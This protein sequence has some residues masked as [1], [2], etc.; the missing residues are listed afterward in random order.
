MEKM[1]NFMV[2]KELIDKCSI[3][4][5]TKVIAKLA[6]V[7]EKDFPDLLERCTNLIQEIRDI[8]DYWICDDKEFCFVGYKSDKEEFPD[9]ALIPLKNFNKINTNELIEFD[10]CGDSVLGLTVYEKSI[11]EFDTDE[12]LGRILYHTTYFDLTEAEVAPMRNAIKNI[13]DVNKLSQMEFYVGVSSYLA[14]SRLLDDD[15]FTKNTY[16]TL[17]GTET[18]VIKEYKKLLK[19]SQ[20]LRR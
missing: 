4:N 3:D 15:T 10:W 16:D 9:I 14:L 12:L 19:E 20:N 8:E 6:Q 18:K 13:E 5:V 2:V 1:F 11:E 17:T 7:D